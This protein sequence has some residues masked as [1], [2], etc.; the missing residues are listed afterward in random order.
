MSSRVPTF[1]SPDNN[2][3]YVLREMFKLNLRLYHL[4]A[5]CSRTKEN[6][7]GMHCDQVTPAQKKI[8]TVLQNKVYVDLNERTECYELTD[9]GEYCIEWAP[10][11]AK[12]VNNSHHKTAQIVSFPAS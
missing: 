10:R 9:T 6:P 1:Q 2:L 4:M 11:L 7:F 12:H 5:F 3:V 8:L